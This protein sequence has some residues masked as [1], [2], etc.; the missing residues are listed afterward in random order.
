MVE[1]IREILLH[2]DKL[3]LLVNLKKNIFDL[4]TLKG[5][6]KYVN[7][8]LFKT[9]HVINSGGSFGERALVRNEDRAASIVCT[10][11]CKFATLD[12]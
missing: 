6:N 5:K 7:I 10:Q 12:R 11:K 1:Q 8:Q 4:V 3:R 2:K 9:V